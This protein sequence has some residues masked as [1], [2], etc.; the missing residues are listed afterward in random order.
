MEIHLD[1]AVANELWWNIFPMAKLNNLEGSPSDHSAIFLEP[2]QKSNAMGRRRF[3]FE[4]AWLT[5]PLCKQIVSNNWEANAG[6]SILEKVKI[7]SID[8]DQWGKKI[9]G[10]FTKRIK[11]CKTKLKYLRNKN[12]DQS[13][14]E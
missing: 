13:M 2:Y 6:W 4:N 10:C 12:D 9:T 8:L 7:C 14:K 1:R 11:E 5:E 3:C